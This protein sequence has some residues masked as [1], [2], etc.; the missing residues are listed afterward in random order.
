MTPGL[1]TR[2]DLGARL[3][4]RCYLS[5]EFVLRSG[6]TSDHYFDKYRFEADPVLLAAVA[7]RLA[8]IVPDDTDVIA[9][10]ELG[11]VPLAT[12]LSSVTGL[13]ARFVRK[14]PKPYGTRLATEGGVVDG[15]RVLVVEDVT[16]TGSQMLETIARLRSEGASVDHALVVI[17]R[18]DEPRRA[19]AADGVSLSALYTEDEI[20]SAATTGSG[21]P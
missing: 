11:G 21:R 13:P 7:G 20:M 12:A 3:F 14:Q 18:G 10:P 8:T 17:V 15:L 1:D 16:S 19:L 4:D 2:R 9:G 5:G 6:A